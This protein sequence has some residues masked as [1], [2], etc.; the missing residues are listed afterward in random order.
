MLQDRLEKL[1]EEINKLRIRP[2]K[3]NFQRERKSWQWRVVPAVPVHQRR[4]VQLPNVIVCTRGNLLL[5]LKRNLTWEGGTG[6]E[7]RKLNSFAE[8]SE[9]TSDD[10]AGN[11]VPCSAREFVMNCEHSPLSSGAEDDVFS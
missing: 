7:E 9:T 8:S 2:N 11:N 5:P 10:C 4:G 6:E 3:I 1:N